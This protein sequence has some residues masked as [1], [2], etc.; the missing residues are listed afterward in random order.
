MVA[1]RD[2]GG[3][4]EWVVLGWLLESFADSRVLHEVGGFGRPPLAPAKLLLANGE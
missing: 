3:G 2:T 1:R 4:D